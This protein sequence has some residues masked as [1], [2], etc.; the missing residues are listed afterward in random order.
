MPTLETERLILRDFALN[1]WEALNAI[2]SDP[3]VA[4]YMHFAAWDEAKR[5]QWLMRM[6]HEA[7]MPHPDTN[8]WAITLRSDGQLIGWL[9]IGASH[10]EAAAGT[11]GCGYALDARCWGQGYMTEA[12]RAA[13]AYE[14]TVL[15]VQRVTAECETPNIASARVMQ[16]CGMTNEGTFFDA[17][18]EGNNWRERHHYAIGAHA[19]EAR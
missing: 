16:K 19:W 13:L 2:V 5:Y 7:S 4:R 15:G 18:F 8:N 9:F 3:A 12:L 11:R 10:E 1:D 17:D 6:V 14:F